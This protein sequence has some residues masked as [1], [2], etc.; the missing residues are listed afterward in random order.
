MKPNTFAQR[1]AALFVSLILL[2]VISLVGVSALETGSLEIKMAANYSDRQEAFQAAET[3]LRVG[4]DFIENA[5]F[6]DSQVRNT[7]TGS[8][9]FEATC[10]DALCFLGEYKNSDDMIDCNPL[11]D[12]TDLPVWQDSALNVWNSGKNFSVPITGSDAEAAYIIEFV[13]FSEKGDGSSFDT[14][15]PNNGSPVFRV[16]ALGI[17]SSEKSRVVLQ[18]TYRIE[19]LEQ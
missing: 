12:T 2:L 7:C 17:S 15:Q 3:A 10:A 5:G 9:C 1:G 11:A 13:C 4:E 19:T 16:T 18:T 6:K 14:S 8:N